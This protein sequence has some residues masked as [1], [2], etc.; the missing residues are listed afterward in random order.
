VPTAECPV[1]VAAKVWTEKSL[2]FLRREFGS[3]V[4]RHEVILPSAE[5]LSGSYSAAPEEIEALVSHVCGLMGVDPAAIRVELFD[6]SE[7]RKEGYLGT[8]EFGY[9][10]A[11]YARMR[12]EASP[13]WARHL[14]PGQGGYL[15][16]G[17]AYLRRGQAAR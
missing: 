1:P 15:T 17:L 6:A 9:A 5:F 10:L 7:R 13:A 8:R 14:S 11:C 2:L 4:L 12:G 16:Q 3:E